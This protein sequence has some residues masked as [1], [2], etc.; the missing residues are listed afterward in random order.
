[1][2]VF[3]TLVLAWVV[4]DLSITRWEGLTLMVFLGGYLTF[5]FVR[6][7]AIEGE[8]VEGE[9]HS[10]A[11]SIGMVAAGMICI[12]IGAKFLV[13]GASSLARAAGISEWAIGV[14]IVA[15]GTSAPELVTSLNSAIKGRHGISAGNLIGSDLF[16]LL[17]VLGLA[18]FI[19]PMTIDASAQ[20]SMMIL[21][22]AVVLVLI[23]MRSGW[24][25][26]RAEGV[27]L[28]LVSLVR[29]WFDLFATRT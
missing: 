19:K 4:S 6:R 8:E 22:G 12:L 5:L 27:V 29:W 26:T 11:R 28:V 9:F 17:G 7:E 2:L 10:M 14:T 16:N 15:A 25:V 18:S 23:F 3:G 20:T 24:K 13:G 1:M 21:I